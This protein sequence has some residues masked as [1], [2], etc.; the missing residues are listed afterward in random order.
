TLE[1]ERFRKPVLRLFHTELEAVYE[2]KNRSL[3]SDGSKM[4]ESI[5]SGLWPTHQY[6]T[7]T[8]IGTVEHLKNPSMKEI[9]KY[10]QNYYVPNN[11]AIIMSGDFDP[12]QAIRLIDANFGKMEPKKVPMYI[13][14]VEAPILKPVVKEVIGPDA[15]KVTIAFRNRGMGS[16]EAD[17]VTLI[18]K[19]L[20][21]DRAGI[22]DLNLN[23]SQKVLSAYSYEMILNDY[24]AH[25]LSGEPKQGQSLEEVKDLL[26][27]QVE[28]VKKG[29]FPDWLLAAIIND[30]KLE[31]IKMLE[32]N[33]KRADQ[34]VSSFVSNIPWSEYV[35]EI[36][37]LAFITKEDIVAFANSQYN[38][39][40]VVV[41]KR[42][43][44]DKN[45]EKVTKPQITPIKV[46]SE[47][48]SPFVASLLKTEAPEIKPVFLDYKNDIKPLS[49]QKKINGSYLKNTENQTF[50][51]YY[52][53]DMGNNHNKKIGLAVDY[54]QYLG[55][56]KY[57]PAQIQE[58]FFKIG[59]SF[60]VFNSDDQIYVNL[61]GLD[62]NFE[63]GLQLFEHLLAD[64]QPNK[65]ALE[66]LVSDMLKS[67]EDAKLSKRAILWS[68]MNNFG[69]YGDKSPF[70][71]ILSETELKSLKP[72]ELVDMIKGL[73]SY[74]HKILY[75]GPQEIK[76]L[77]KT[78]AKHHQLPKKLKDIP[79][80]LDFIYL[81]NK[82]TKVYVVDYDM[83]QAEILMVSKAD[84]Y[85]KKQ[86]PITTLFNEY[87][88]SGMSS[89]LFQEMRESRALAY[90]V[91]ASYS[92]PAK[93]EKPHYVTAYI[94]TQVDKL[95]EAMKGMFEMFN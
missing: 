75:Y 62:E 44:T 34:M 84:A 73:T 23:Q 68:A 37:R 33:Y 21:N 40:Y 71:N 54:L 46:N 7:Q 43:G 64:A 70:T 52:I 82:E 38:D 42:T 19:I 65:E 92:T 13:A 27:E 16:K 69:I 4:W 66:N 50:N 78:L 6:G 51:L 77:E 31:Q 85:D 22:I 32:S 48:E 83:Q 94:G 47:E 1:G 2:E 60:G 58:E 87:F 72:E 20:F 49:V 80:E 67:R 29:E 56:S 8:T 35:T 79:K 91:F 59:C 90:S 9:N 53:F 86:T 76:P 12:D 93:K 30:L 17:L 61:K 26:L 3:D 11:M 18:S 88:G 5:F 10:Y 95:P 14:P 24:S 36:E 55:T 28:K 57:T 25:I 89:I 81:P 15:E 63:A 41:Y 74:K 39:N 45:I